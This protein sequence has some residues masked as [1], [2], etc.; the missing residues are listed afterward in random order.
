M[1]TQTQR[2]AAREEYRRMRAEW[3]GGLPLFLAVLPRPH[4][5]YLVLNPDAGHFGL[6][7]LFIVSETSGVCAEITTKLRTLALPTERIAWV[8]PEDTQGIHHRDR[9]RAWADAGD[10][11]RAQLKETHIPV[12]TS[13][14]HP[15][16][17]KHLY[18]G[19]PR[20]EA[21][22]LRPVLEE[23]E[24]QDRDI[25]SPTDY[26]L[27]FGL[28]RLALACDFAHGGI[29]LPSI[30]HQN[31]YGMDAPMAE[32]FARDILTLTELTK[33]EDVRKFASLNSHL[34]E[35]RRIASP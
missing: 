23:F 16:S 6:A 29:I 21:V 27:H 2:E 1:I 17:D 35:L 3:R 25:D 33:R 5:Q 13:H 20:Y 11:E 10:V 24:A 9:F 18:R 31:P 12:I 4:S 34:A 22:P 28:A 14:V 26:H 15:G 19:S 32:R 30:V 8:P 7:A